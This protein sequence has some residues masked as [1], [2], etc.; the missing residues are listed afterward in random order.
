M[1]KTNESNET[2]TSTRELTPFE[3]FELQRQKRMVLHAIIEETQT[4]VT[5]LELVDDMEALGVDRERVETLID[6]KIIKMAEMMRDHF[7]VEA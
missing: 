4:L 6:Q 7:G 3:Q 2:T 5:G 1:P